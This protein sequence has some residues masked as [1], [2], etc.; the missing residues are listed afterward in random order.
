MD[1]SENILAGLMGV[2]AGSMMSP[3]LV[4]HFRESNHTDMLQE[5]KDNEQRKLQL[6]E[7]ILEELKAIR[8]DT[9]MV[10]EVLLFQPEGPGAHA[11]KDHFH[12]IL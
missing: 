8:Q 7:A 2:M 12:N 5:H 10:K 4:N 6:L 11:A 9:A 3:G 1:N